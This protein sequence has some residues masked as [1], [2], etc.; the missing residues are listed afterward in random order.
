MMQNGDTDPAYSCLLYLA[1]R[2]DITLEQRYWLAFLYST[3][4]CGPTA[5]YI[6]NEFPDY[7]LVNFDRMERWWTA[8]R[9]KVVFTTD[10]AWVRSRNQF[11]DMV[12]SYKKVIHSSIQAEKYFTLKT[13]DA[14]LTYNNC[15][16]EFS[17]V[18]QMGRFGLFLYLES[19]YELTGYPMSP[20]GLDLKNA[21]SS[22]NGLCYALGRDDLVR[23]KDKTPLK[24]SDLKYLYKAF[25]DLFTEIKEERPKDTTVWSV[26]TTLCAYK[27]YKYG[28]RWIG[29]YIE[30]QR[31]EI[32][33]LENNVKYGVDWSVLW[34]YR[35]EYFKHKWLKEI[36]K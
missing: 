7:K 25:W 11:V 1:N 28:K 24:N 15:Y 17:N 30:R 22:R 27:K 3:C 36:Q 2:F 4:Y 31:K 9:D 35:K 10:K 23:H 29:Y 34:Q 6:F 5:W 32:E 12:R 26:E 20:S 21:V 16:S 33:K 13:P 8:N 14:Y 19:V 18:Y